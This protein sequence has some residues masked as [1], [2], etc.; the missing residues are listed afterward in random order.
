MDIER[1]LRLSKEQYIPD[2]P[3]EVIVKAILGLKEELE[4]MTQE[5]SYIRQAV[6]ELA[7]I[8]WIE[9]EIKD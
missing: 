7:H 5:I 6:G 4:N 2:A 1:E 8:E 9:A 3:H